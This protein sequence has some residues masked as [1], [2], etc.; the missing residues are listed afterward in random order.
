MNLIKTSQTLNA[1][2]LSVML[3][4]SCLF[5]VGIGP[6]VKTLWAG[7]TLSTGGAVIL[8]FVGVVVLAGLLRR[9]RCCLLV[10]GVE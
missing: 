6:T 7:S 9:R 5:I 8:L 10:A 1:R 2:R 3:T 4:I